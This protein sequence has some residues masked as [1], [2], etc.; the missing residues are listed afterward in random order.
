MQNCNYDIRI[1]VW[2]PSRISSY[3]GIPDIYIT[4]PLDMWLDPG[5]GENAKWY[6]DLIYGCH[7]EKDHIDYA[8]V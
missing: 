7:S 1:F 4:Q 8:V 3:A 2:I 6:D 5:L